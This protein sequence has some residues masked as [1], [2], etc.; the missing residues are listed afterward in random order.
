MSLHFIHLSDIHIRSNWEED[1]GIVITNFVSDIKK[2]VEQLDIKK[3]YVVFS[4][5]LVL[6]GDDP[7]LYDIFLK[8]FGSALDAIGLTKEQR[9]CVPGN[10]DISRSWIRDN[11]L[12]HDGVLL[13]PLT[14]KQF[15]DYVSTSTFLL[16]EKFEHYRK[17]EQ[18]FSSLG[19]DDEKL[20]G[21][22][23]TLSDDVGV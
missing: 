1:Q 9:I 14:E 22:G 13:Q 12:N 15:N 5:D 19:I 18:S 11:K 20:T 2:Q 23:W 21:K 17:F 7:K 3:V 4:G 8:E 10:H 16:A 6:A